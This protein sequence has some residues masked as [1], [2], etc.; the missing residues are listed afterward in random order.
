MATPTDI[1]ESAQ[2][3]F[4]AL[5]NRVG[6]AGL[7]KFFDKQKYPTYLDFKM[8]WNKTFKTLPIEK[9]FQAHVKSGKASLSE[10]EELL[11]GTKEKSK[12]KKNEWYHSSLEIA[13]QLIK[14]IAKISSKF[15]YVKSGNWQD[16]FWR[17]GDKEVMDNMAKLF[18]MANDYQK[19]L[20]KNNK[21]G[22][23]LARPFDNIN[24]WTTA[25]IYFAAEKAKKEIEELVKEK[26]IDYTKL[27]ALVS[28]QISEGIL[29]PL[30]LKKQPNEVTIKKVNFN[31][32]EEQKSI[33]K[34][35]Y[36]GISEWKFFDKNK[37][38]IKNYTRTLLVYMSK[39][40]QI[41][42]QMRHDPSSEGY[43]GVIKIV[44]AGA[45]EGSLSAG[46]LYHILKT[47]D[48]GFSNKWYKAYNEAN[49]KFR[50]YKDVLD[51]ELKN[52]DRKRYDIER[53]QYSAEVTNSINPLLIDWLKRNPDKADLFI[54]GVYTYATAR[55]NNSAKYVIAK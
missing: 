47:V 4:C 8:N 42:L 32:V 31:R 3:L 51:K 7:A 13:K 33:D 22:A 24:K 54:R 38:D 6:T 34:L 14:D 40:K 43:K 52:S 50:K 10:I 26:K 30:S 20:V 21:T 2:A 49:E 18:K 16:V 46:P 45:F 9:A 53:E 39:D 36:G 23:K 12:Y 44:G 35:G 17:H 25:D 11:H 37:M 19:E 5:A 15:S 48:D 55:S 28:R 41:E 1:Q 29:L 27:N